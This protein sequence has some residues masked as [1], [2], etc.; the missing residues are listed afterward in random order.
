MLNNQLLI[1]RQN[2]QAIDSQAE[3]LWDLQQKS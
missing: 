1:Y 2:P 3:F